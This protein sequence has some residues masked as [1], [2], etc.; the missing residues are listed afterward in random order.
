MIDREIPTPGRDRDDKPSNELFEDD[1]LPDADGDFLGELDRVLTTEDDD[2]GHDPQLADVEEALES[3]ALEVG[4]E[5]DPEP[6]P[7]QGGARTQPTPV[8]AAGR[9]DHEAPPMSKAVDR[10]QGLR[11]QRRRVRPPVE[12]PPHR[13]E[14]IPPV[15]AVVRSPA[16]EAGVRTPPPSAVRPKPAGTARPGPA[17]AHDEGGTPPII[18]KRATAAGTAVPRPVAPPHPAEGSP[19]TSG[20]LAGIP[21]L[22]L[23]A[24][25][26]L[27]IIGIVTGVVGIWLQSDTDTELARM[28]TRLAE[29]SG[30]RRDAR[31][32]ANAERL[33]MLEAEVARLRSLQEEF[34]GTLVQ[35]LIHE[36]ERLGQDLERLEATLTELQG[37]LESAQVRLSDAEKRPKGVQRPAETVTPAPAAGSGAVAEK[38]AW[39]VN[40]MSFRRQA[41][42][43]KEIARLRDDGIPATLKSIEREGQTW[44]RLQVSGFADVLQAK[45]YAKKI[46][47]RRDLSS[48]WVGRE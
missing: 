30:P 27:A 24:L 23:G 13:P 48:A 26:L 28:E 19:P 29:V 40:L 16:A 39:T 43:E 20:L 17:P 37:G 41:V 1:F 7:A 25:G 31:D 32:A 42:A 44:Y 47:A 15:A 33:R 11:E 38:G 18:Q 12:T 5:P 3:L 4:P 21:H 9:S 34:R 45:A 46:R 22:W 8:P 14:R 2:P 36:N 10:L 6:E 35:R